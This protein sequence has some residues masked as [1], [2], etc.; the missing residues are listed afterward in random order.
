MKSTIYFSN[1]EKRVK[2]YFSTVTVRKTIMVTDRKIKAIGRE[3]RITRVSITTRDN[4]TPTIDN[5]R[6]DDTA[7]TPTIIITAL[8]RQRRAAMVDFWETIVSET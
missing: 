7:E 1:R 6:R 5:I 8:S 2:Y 4:Q 3:I